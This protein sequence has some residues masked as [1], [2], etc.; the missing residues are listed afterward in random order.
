MQMISRALEGNYVN[1][2][3]FALYGDKALDDALDIAIKLILSIPKSD[4]MVRGTLLRS[5]AARV[6]V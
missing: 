2:G 5:R 4:L 6:A 1:F 3:V